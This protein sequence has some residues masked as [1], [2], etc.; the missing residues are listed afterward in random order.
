M[1]EPKPRDL[2]ALL[3][4][5]TVVTGIVDAGSF[6]GLGRVFVANMTGNVVFLAALFVRHLMRRGLLMA[7]RCSGRSTSSPTAPTRSG[8]AR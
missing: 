1:A 5:L 2:A 4:T 6:L 3:L 8:T 7:S